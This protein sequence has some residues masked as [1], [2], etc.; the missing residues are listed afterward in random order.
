MI[1]DV[2]AIHTPRMSR[3]ARIM[4]FYHTC[5]GTHMCMLCTAHEMSHVTRTNESCHTYKGVMSHI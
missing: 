1:P 2:T 3:V 5:E 4:E